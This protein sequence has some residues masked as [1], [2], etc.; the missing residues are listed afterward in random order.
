MEEG[1]EKRSSLVQSKKTALL[2]KQRKR[3]D[4][5]ELGQKIADNQRQISDIQVCALLAEQ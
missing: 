1:I 2:E 4:V 3:P 5:A